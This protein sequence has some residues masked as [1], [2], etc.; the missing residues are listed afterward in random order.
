MPVHGVNDGL[1]ADSFNGKLAGGI[2]V[3]HEDEVRGLKHFPEVF[4]QH[5][6]AR[7][8]VRLEVHDEA[9]RLEGAGRLQGGGCFRG[10]WP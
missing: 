7:V 5:L 8:A 6:G 1:A 10:W 9:L 2:H 3:S 4:R